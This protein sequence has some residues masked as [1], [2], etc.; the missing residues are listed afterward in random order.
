MLCA[1]GAVLLW[2]S[3]AVIGRHLAQAGVS[4]IVVAF[5]RVAIGALG[6]LAWLALRHQ[7]PSGKRG[8]LELGRWSLAALLMYAANM[9]VFHWALGS[10]PASVVMVLESTAPLA[11][12]L[13]GYLL[14]GESAGWRGGAAA[15]CAMAGVAVIGL[16]RPV[17]GPVAAGTGGY[18][19]GLV[20]ALL[21]GVTWGGYTLA[22]R[23]LGLGGN[24]TIPAAVVVLGGSAVLLLPLAALTGGWPA[25]PADW[26]WTVVL[27]LAHTALATVLWQTA[28]GHLPAFTVSL[29]FLG[30]IVLTMANEWLFLGEHLGPVQLLGAGVVLAAVLVGRTAGRAPARQ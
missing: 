4:M 23:G 30:T 1:L 18:L 12:L 5:L 27:G 29:L 28:L 11:V 19:A 24:R 15:L 2:G 6:L 13:G 21:A 9:V 16:S 26:L 25:T 10:V 3:N 8:G 7:W 22:C 17:G 20:L 14:F